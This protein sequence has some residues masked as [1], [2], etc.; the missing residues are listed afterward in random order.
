MSRNKDGADS[1][2]GVLTASIFGVAYWGRLVEGD[3]IYST[4]CM[5]YTVI[6]V[7]NARI[8]IIF[9]TGTSDLQP[10]ATVCNSRMAKLV[11]RP[12][13]HN[14]TKV[15]SVAQSGYYIAPAFSMGYKVRNFATE[16]PSKSGNLPFH[17]P[18]IHLCGWRTST[19]AR[20]TG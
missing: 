18:A 6:T 13:Q 14:G 12:T 5:H 4:Y 10:C 19:P 3:K 17:T 16:T 2:F 15:A 9:F 1:Y 8:R 7:V 11:E 20:V